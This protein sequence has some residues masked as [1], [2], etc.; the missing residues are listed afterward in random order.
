MPMPGMGPMPPS[1]TGGAEPPK[2][3]KIK[4][5]Y[6]FVVVFTWKEPAPSD[7]LRPIKI[8]EAPAAAPTMAT[9]PSA[10]PSSPKSGSGDSE[11]GG[12]LRGGRDPD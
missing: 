4:P 7:K 5:R 8:K 6:E 1:A 12:G 3:L 9:P 2:G 10:P 11:G